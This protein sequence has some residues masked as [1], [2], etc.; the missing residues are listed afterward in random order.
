MSAT[1][2]ES[3]CYC[4]AALGLYVHGKKIQASFSNILPD[5]LFTPWAASSDSSVDDRL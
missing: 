5:L 2:P 3:R 4:Y 1:L